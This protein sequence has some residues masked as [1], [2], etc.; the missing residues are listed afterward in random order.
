MPD[1]EQTPTIGRQLRIGDSA[2][3]FEA[4]S[5]AGMVRLS[6]FRGR[7]LLFFS[8]PGDFTPACTSEFLS[9]AQA[10]D[11]FEA[12]EC[13]VLGHSVDS[14]FSHLAWVR[15]IR[16][17]LGVTVPFPIIEDPSLAI[18]RAYGMV[19]S[20]MGNAASVRAA[21]YIDPD[22]II[23]A[24]TWYPLSVGRSVD[25][26]LRMIAAL[27]AT[28]GKGCIAPEGWQPGDPLLAEPAYTASEALE[29]MADGPWFYRKRP[30]RKL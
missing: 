13:S 3:D 14:L 2:P 17:W 30:V 5:T 4:R 25:E 21:Y 18:A 15:A 6:Q 29:D 19:S 8:H 27:Q 16:D 24:M 28:R 22:G 11:R 20:E 10:M 26:M 7:W 9:L 1:S 23:Q 12:L